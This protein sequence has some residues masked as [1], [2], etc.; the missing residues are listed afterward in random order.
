MAV[1][2]QRS[3]KELCNRITFA[4]CPLLEPAFMEGGFDV[5]DICAPGTNMPD[6]T[7]GYRRY[8]CLSEH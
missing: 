7:N 8:D 5:G 6:L 4:P 1:R 2:L 3:E